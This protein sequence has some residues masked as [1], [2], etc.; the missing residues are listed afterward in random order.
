MDELIGTYLRLHVNLTTGKFVLCNPKG[1][2]K[3][4]SVDD[5]VLSDVTFKV[6]ER[7]RLWVV[8]HKMRQVHAWA[9]GTLVS[10]DTAPLSEGLEAITYNPFRSG[11]FTTRAGEVVAAAKWVTFTERKAWRERE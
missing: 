5:A 10:A 8:E 1:G 7:Q 4:C 9:F 6:S 3:I 2:K 11:D